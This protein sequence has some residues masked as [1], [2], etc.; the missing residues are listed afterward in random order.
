[1]ENYQGVKFFYRQTQDNFSYDHRLPLLNHWAYLFS[2]LGLAPVHPEGAYGN[3][4]YRTGKT[5]FVISKSGMVPS[6]KLQ[7][8]DF[9]HVVGFDAAATTFLAEGTATPSS[10][11]FLHNSLYQSLPGINAILHGHCSLLSFH[12]ATLNI[13]VTAKFCDYGTPELAE[14]ALTLID[15]TT[16]FFILRDHGFVAMGEN[17]DQAGKLTL[18]YFSL[19]IKILQ[20]N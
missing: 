10:E 14:S 6:E 3:L 19:L 8:A 15:Q 4:S 11:T 20:S 5:S 2:Q 16:R 17:I 18:D 12:A 9:C 13:P 1:M 7:S